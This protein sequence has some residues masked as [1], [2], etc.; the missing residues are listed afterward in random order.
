M[1]VK[2]FKKASELNNYDAKCELAKAYIFGL[3]VEKNITKAKSILTVA[4]KNNYKKAKE[5]WKKHN[6]EIK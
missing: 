4:Y 6:L 3:G 5:I 1:A 2:Y